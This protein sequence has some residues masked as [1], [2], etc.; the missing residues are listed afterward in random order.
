[1]IMAICAAHLKDA[2]ALAARHR[3][4]HRHE[5]PRASRSPCA[6]S[7]ITVI[8]TKVGDRYVLEQMRPSGAVLGGEQSGHIIFLEHNTTGDGLV[9]ALQLASRRASA[10]GSRSP[11]CA[12]VM[13]RYPQVLVNVPV[14][15]KAR[16]GTSAAVADAIARRRGASSATTGRVL[17]RASGTE[18]LVRVMAEAADEDDGAGRRR[19]ARRRSCG[20]SSG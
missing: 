16:L 13:R 5:Q 14:A 8:K 15:D 7:G 17:V 6:S 4:R 12:A 9:T 10:T 18:P 11:S 1:M 20:P 19:P 2:G 3:R